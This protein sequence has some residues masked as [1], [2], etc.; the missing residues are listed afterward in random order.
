MFF[1]CFFLLF[2]CRFSVVFF[3]TF[4]KRENSFYAYNN[5][6]LLSFILSLYRVYPQHKRKKHD[7]NALLRYTTTTLQ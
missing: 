3:G 2:V 4:R 7:A 5:D 6:A 1:G